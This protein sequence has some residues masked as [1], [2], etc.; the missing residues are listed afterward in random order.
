MWLSSFCN[1]MKT[2]LVPG[3]NFMG[4]LAITDIASNLSETRLGYA[5]LRL[6]FRGG[7]T[8]GLNV[9]PTAAAVRLSRSAHTPHTKNVNAINTIAPT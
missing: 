2:S 3:K 4:R 5:G 7:G 1:S 6:E 9:E 8:G